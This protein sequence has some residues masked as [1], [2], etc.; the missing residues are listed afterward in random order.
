MKLAG[1]G[2]RMGRSPDAFASGEPEG[3][4]MLEARLHRLY[5]YRKSSLDPGMGGFIVVMTT[6]ARG[7]RAPVS[8]AKCERGGMRC[9]R[10]RTK[11]AD[12]ALSTAR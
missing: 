7:H 9:P 4:E 3:L 8:F 6:R 1:V 12:F 2:I 11:S 5:R 10:S